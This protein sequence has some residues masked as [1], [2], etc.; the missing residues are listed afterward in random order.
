MS[1]REGVLIT[2]QMS[3][4][5]TDLNA[6]DNN[7]VD[8]NTVNEKTQES[9]KG[10]NSDTSI[11]N[12]GDGSVTYDQFKE[13]LLCDSLD[14]VNV[15]ALK[16]IELL[17]IGKLDKGATASAENYKSR[18]ERWFNQKQKNPSK[19]DVTDGIEDLYIQC[20][21]LIQVRCKRGS[22]DTVECYRVL[23]FFTKYY[24]K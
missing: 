23:D 19:D 13:L 10:V 16:L 2:I 18:N 11:G 3:D 5:D 8:D 15:C 6:T 14:E 4:T 9:S 20:G 7:A 21:R 24:N 17:S 1:Q 22:A 12:G